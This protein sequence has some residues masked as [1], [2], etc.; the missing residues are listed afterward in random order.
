MCQPTE[1]LAH[2]ESSALPQEHMQCSHQAAA[3]PQ[4]LHSGTHTGSQ[5]C[6][7]REVL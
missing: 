6:N 4:P 3:S 2:L 1:V 7:T 5:R